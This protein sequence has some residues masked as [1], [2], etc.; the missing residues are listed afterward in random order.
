MAEPNGPK[1]GKNGDIP[2][3]EDVALHP[4]SPSSEPF[5]EQYGAT[6]TITMPGREV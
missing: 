2:K 4:Q 6:N 3:L 5:E 1:K